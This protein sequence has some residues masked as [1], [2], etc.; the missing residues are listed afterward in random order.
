MLQCPT[1]KKMN[2]S[3]TI[4]LSVLVLLL[5]LVFV[6]Q[7]T[8]AQNSNQNTNRRIVVFTDDRVNK[9]AQEAIIKGT[10]G[11]IIKRLG[12]INAQAV[13][14]PEQ[15]E[16]ALRVHPS[17]KRI[18]ADVLVRATGKPAPPPQPSQTT[19]WGI[20][21]VEADL[22]WST[23]NGNGVKVA[24]VDTGIDLTH[25]DLA[26]NIKGGV[27]TINSRK[28]ANDDNGHGTHVAGI[29]AALNNS[30]GVVGVGPVASLYAVK[31]LD[32]NGSGFLSD[33]IEGLEWAVT[34]GMQVVNMSLGTDS[35]I[36]S[37]HDAVVKVNQAGIV[38]VGAAG[39]DGA[40]VD[41]PGAYPEVIGVAAVQKNSDGTLS[42]AS[43]T[44]RGGEVDLSAP[45]VSILSTYKGGSYATLSGTSMA[46]PHVTGVAALVLT[47]LPGTYDLNSNG[48]WD[49][50][51][52][53][54]KL[55]ATSEN[56]GLDPTF[57]GSGL[58]RADL[59][60]Q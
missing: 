33:V 35:D 1:L 44:S 28:S 45:G 26:S 18:D 22:A 23:N 39:N 8:Q 58:V 56:I 54:N 57:F 10:G 19:P 37:F 20:D 52:V 3:L 32:R 4:L 38:Q 50:A 41:F 31:V 9:D 15:A 5:G 14:L 34:N 13:Y 29:T 25:P 60:I 27:N 7:P 53:Q 40:A 30:I 17:V 46:T 51:E 12:L 2:K 49:P 6:H 55:M 48:S 16:A 42:V 24:I 21:R 43:F 11:V 36:Q 47:I 59:A